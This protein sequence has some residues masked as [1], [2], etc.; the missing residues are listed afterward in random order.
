MAMVVSS[1]SVRADLFFQ[2]LRDS[3]HGRAFP[4]GTG[5]VP[6][7]AQSLFL[8]LAEF[9][10]AGSQL[11]PDKHFLEYMALCVRKIPLNIE[12]LASACRIN[13]QFNSTIN[14]S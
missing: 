13:H 5:I 11:L 2:I 3:F 7:G 9:H 1:R 12:R 8:L 14:H 4:D 6:A 10:R